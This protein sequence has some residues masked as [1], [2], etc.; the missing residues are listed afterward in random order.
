MQ[1]PSERKR[2][3]SYLLLQL[4]AYCDRGIACR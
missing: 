1:S 3:T 2:L 4:K